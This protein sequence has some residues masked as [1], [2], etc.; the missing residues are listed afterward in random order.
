MDWAETDGFEGA[1]V[2]IEREHLFESDAG[3]EE[4]GLVVA[5]EEC[6]GD[7]VDAATAR[8]IVIAFEDRI[9]ETVIDT[10]DLLANMEGM[11]HGVDEDRTEGMEQNYF[12]QS[13]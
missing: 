9:G 1:F 2:G 3:A 7:R 5:S 13:R 12:S 11:V 8:D 10:D 6:F 4:G